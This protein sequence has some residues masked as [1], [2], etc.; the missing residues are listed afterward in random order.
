MNWQLVTK[1][2]TDAYFP[3]LQHRTSALQLVL[4][5]NAINGNQ[6]H[7]N[8]LVGKCDKSDGLLFYHPPSKQLITA[9]NGYRFDTTHPSGPDF[10]LQY[11]NSFTFHTKGSLDFIHRPPTHEENDIVFA[12]TNA[13]AT[14]HRA[15]VLNTPI[16]EEEE[17]LVVQFID[18]DDIAKVD[19]Q[20]VKDTDPTNPNPPA[21]TDTPTDNPFPLSPW[22][23]PDAK[24]TLFLPHLMSKPKQGYLCRSEDRREWSFQEPGRKADRSSDN[25]TTIPLAKFEEELAQ[26]LISNRKLF[27]GWKNSKSVITACLLRA[28]SNIIARHVSAKGLQIMATPSLHKHHELPPGNKNI[29]DLSYME[30]YNGLQNLDTWEIITEAEYKRL[31]PICGKALPKMAISTIKRDGEGNPIRAK[32]RIVALGN[33]DPHN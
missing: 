14:Y 30:K 11:D 23:Q 24:V 4:Q 2:I 3:F 16:N 31:L 5:T 15:R 17:N 21:P 26:S 28:K 10:K 13:G 8:V 27:K 25:D 9:A 33:L 20:F 19:P 18:S 1:S 32:Y 22:I 6:K 29:W 12:S 7:S